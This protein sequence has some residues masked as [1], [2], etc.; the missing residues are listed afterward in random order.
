[1]NEDASPNYNGSGLVRRG[2]IVV[3][4]INYR[5]GPYGFLASSEVQQ[6]ASLNNGL[7]DQRMALQ[8]V[9]KYISFV[10][11]PR[12]AVSTWP[13]SDQQF[14]G[15]PNHVILGG[16]SAGAGSIV[17]QLSAYGGRNDS[18]FIASAAES[19]SFPPV[20]TVAESQYQ[21]NNLTARLGCAGQNDTL[22]CLRGVDVLTFQQNN[23]Q[24]PYPNT[25]AAP[26]YV[27]FLEQHYL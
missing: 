5:V 20:L 19:Q 2:N 8:W 27:G 14:G 18:L 7:K 24:V 11:L 3:V 21:Y 1:M 13:N 9:Q 6:G 23:I 16:S 4:D 10:S 22:A 25:R 12:R 26:I 17:L 15:D